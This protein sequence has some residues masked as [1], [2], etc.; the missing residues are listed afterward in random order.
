MD[1]RPLLLPTK[2]MLLPLGIICA[3]PVIVLW[4][5][6][7]PAWLIVIGAVVSVAILRKSI[8]LIVTYVRYLESTVKRR[9]QRQFTDDD[10]LEQAIRR[11]VGERIK[12]LY[13]IKSASRPFGEIIVITA[14]Y[15]VLLFIAMQDNPYFIAAASVVL[16]QHLVAGVWARLS[17]A[18]MNAIVEVLDD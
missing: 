9:Y 17:A 10:A 12:T 18:G 11:Q 3:A 16:A 7:A 8:I 13:A 2:R 4:W 5:A 1:N 14:P 15:L 6:D